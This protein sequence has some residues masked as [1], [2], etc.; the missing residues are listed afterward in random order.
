MVIVN[1]QAGA[2]GFTTTIEAEGEGELVKLTISSDCQAVQGLAGELR[3]V[4]SMDVFAPLDETE[5]YAACRRNL[6][7]SACPVPCAILKAVEAAADLP[8][9]RMSTSPCRGSSFSP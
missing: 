6:R 3:T 2:C 9:P 5:M 7:H 4:D 1:V 8:C